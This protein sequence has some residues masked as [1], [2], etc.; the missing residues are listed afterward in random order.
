MKRCIPLLFLLACPVFSQSNSGELRLHVAD[1]SGRHIQ[2]T[3]HLL[4]QANQYS[5]DLETDNHGNL[6]IARL[7]YGIY[8]LE[9]DHSGFASVVETVA[10]RSS[11]PITHSVSLKL[12]TVKQNVA[13]QAASTLI[14]PEQP[15][16]V[17]QVGSSF[18]QN[19]L[20]SIPG[21]SLED[22]VLA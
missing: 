14:D 8:R 6:D 18:I 1:P 3:I 5:T 21:R 20:S 15:G 16:N 17:D 2:A 11:I 9:I 22:L 7:P 4:S 19:R 12:A 10:I 13:V